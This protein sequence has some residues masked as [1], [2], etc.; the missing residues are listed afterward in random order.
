MKLLG[1]GQGCNFGQD[2]PELTR[3]DL[4]QRRNLVWACSACVAWLGLDFETHRISASF[5]ASVPEFNPSTI[6]IHMCSYCINHSI[7][8]KYSPTRIDTMSTR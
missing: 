7:Y 5:G 8:G 4:T 2:K 1:L 6:L 3:L